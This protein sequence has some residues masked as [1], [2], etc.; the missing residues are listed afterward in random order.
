MKHVS[1]ALLSLLICTGSVLSQIAQGPASGSVASGVIVNTDNFE[2]NDSPVINDPPHMHK[3]PPF[4]MSPMPPNMPAPTAPEGS[5]VFHDPS[6]NPNSPDS[7]PPITLASFIGNNQT[8]GI[9][10]DPHLAVGPSHIIQV[11]NSSFRISDKSGTTIKTIGANAWYQSTLSNS[12]PFDPKVFY[13][14]HANRWLMVWDNQNDATQ[15]GYFLVSVSDDDNPIGQWLNWALPSNVY[16]STVSGTWQ[17]YQG[18]GYDRNAFYITGRHFGYVS[19]YFGNAVRVLPKAQFL[20]STPGAITW[21]DFWALRDVNGNDVDGIR[22]AIVL[23]A[24][25]EYYLAGPPSFSG[26]TYFALYRITNTLGTPAISCVNVPATAWSGAPP[27]GQPNGVAPFE[28]GTSRV[29]HEPIYRDSSL[30]MAHSVGNAGFSNVRYVR[31]NV[32][33]NTTIEDVSFGASGYYHFYP[34]LAVDK[35]NNIGITFSRSSFS[36]FAGAYYTWRFATDPA[37]LRPTEL[38]RSGA[39]TYFVTG[40]G[41][42][43][44]WGDYMGAALDPA[45][46]NNLWFLTEYVAATNTF[47]V[48]VHGIRMAPYTGARVASTVASRDFERVEVG[49]SSDTM[50]IK[51]NNIGTNTLT[52]SGITKSNAAMNLLNLPSFPLNLATYDSVKIKVFFRPSAHGNVNDTIRIASNDAT[53]SIFRIPLTGKGVVVG[54]AV[55]GRLYAASGPPD[56]SKL[57]TVNTTTGVATPVGETGVTEIQGMTIH[58]S[59]RELY[60]FSSSTTASR[61]YRISTG[62]GDVLPAKSF[63]LGNV[64]AIAFAGDASLYAGINTGSLYRVNIGTGDTTFIG[65]HTSTIVYASFALNPITNKLWAS[66]RPPIINRD[67]IYTVNTSTGVATEVGSTGGNNITPAIAF[68]ARGRLFG[69]KGFSTQIDTLIVIDTTTAFGTRIGAMGFAGIQAMATRSD[70]TTSVREIAATIP[71]KFSLE[72]N[73]PNPFNPETEIRF[74]ISEISHVTLKVFDVLGREVATLVNEKLNPGVYEA[75]FGAASLASGM[76]LY[77]LEAGSFVETKKMLLL[78]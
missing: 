51:I 57:Y 76:Y 34:A 19:G 31:I 75:P 6:V 9:P 28:S 1:I 61:L 10:P 16:G 55:A 20:G 45:D 73:Y 35:D 77:R 15:T 38:M 17:D 13:D 41:T 54:T 37:G 48:W 68:D 52:V 67:K 50:E 29:R 18:V 27:A 5:N 3:H 58:P 63:P 72:Q 25:E 30:W 2:S 64:R 26:G 43:N 74:Q 23:S 71:N 53:T 21:W 24:P 46:K 33:T 70:S 62:G 78:R 47:G 36:E 66:V 4:Q 69:L 59:T 39:G 42:R 56:V 60:G 12:G 14:H 8:N 49:L 65:A 44:R 7:P 32:P 22:P 11:V 40:G